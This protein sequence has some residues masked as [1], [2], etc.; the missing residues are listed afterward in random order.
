LYENAATQS[1]VFFI[2]GSAHFAGAGYHRY[3][4]AGAGT[5]ESDF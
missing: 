4:S 3:T 1:L 2:R 5:Q